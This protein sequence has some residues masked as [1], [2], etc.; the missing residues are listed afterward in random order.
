MNLF[1]LPQTQIVF[2]A[3]LVKVV[4]EMERNLLFTL[5]Q[6]PN[7]TDMSIGGAGVNQVDFYLKK[8]ISPQW[9]GVS[10]HANTQLER[11]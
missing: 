10:S 9:R 3:C 1:L 4:V 7:W 11:A 8:L 5:V 6:S 2:V